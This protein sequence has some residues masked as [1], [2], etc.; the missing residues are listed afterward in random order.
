MES[1]P[2]AMY[3][4]EDKSLGIFV[5]HEYNVTAKNIVDEILGGA[6]VAG[7][8]VDRE[9]LRNLAKIIG[10]PGAVRDES[11]PPVVL[12]HT[13]ALHFE[14]VM[15]QFYLRAA[16]PYRIKR[17]CRT[18]ARTVVED[19]VRVAQ[20]AEHARRTYENAVTGNRISA[21][22]LVNGGHSGLAMLRLLSAPPKPSLEASCP[23]CDSTDFDRFEVTYCP[24][25]HSL[26]DEFL[27]IECPDC[28]HDFIA[29][30]REHVWTTAD[31]AR[32]D[33]NVSYKHS[34]VTNAT[35][36]LDRFLRD[37]QLDFLKSHITA[38]SGIFG[39]ARCMLIDNRK[40]DTIILVTAEGIHW[41][42]K[43]FLVL[44]E[45]RSVSWAD[46]GRARTNS[47]GDGMELTLTNGGIITFDKFTGA[48]AL[49][50]IGVPDKLTDFDTQTIRSLAALMCRRF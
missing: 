44:T 6:A 32:Q 34:A 42:S 16:L 10:E 33:F 38:D 48:G 21:S 12:S 26:R 2:G 11:G 8:E 50:G 15:A 45:D 41:S 46:I 9:V 40:R 31:N 28:D 49:L 3:L 27:L 43:R 19:P 25:C 35:A 24:A 37:G 4:S 14:V 23:S 5:P 7:P 47:T 1:Y 36:T 17:V 29:S 39:V 20:R 13:E 22:Q 30:V 18:C